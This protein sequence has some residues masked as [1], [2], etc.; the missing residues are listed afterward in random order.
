MA[1][2]PYSAP[3]LINSAADELHGIPVDS[4][5][6][7]L[8][9]PAIED[10]DVDTTMVLFGESQ[11]DIVELHIHNLKNVL[12]ESAYNVEF[13]AL[14]AF[15]NLATTSAGPTPANIPLYSSRP[16]PALNNVEI[17]LHEIFRSLGYISGKFKFKL[18]FHRNVLG[19]INSPA[20]IIGINGERTILDLEY[21]FPTNFELSPLV[22]SFGNR[23]EYYVN[24][25][26]NSLHRVASFSKNIDLST[27]NISIYSITLQ[28]PLPV[29]IGVGAKCCVDI[30]LADPQSD[31]II[32]LPKKKVDPINRLRNPNFS[33]ETADGLAQSTA[34]K[35]WDQ[36]LGSNPT[37]SQQLINKLI[38]S[39]FDSIDLNIDYRQYDKFVFYGSAV[40]RL[41]NFRYKTGLLEYYTGL[42]STL[43]SI[44]P[45]ASE[46]GTNKNSVT[47]KINNVLSGFDGYEK[48][49]YYESS[50]Y[51]S[52]SYGEFTPSTWPKI[53]STA[54]YSLYSISSSQGNDWF[55]GQ[56]TS[57]SLYDKQNIN[58]LVYLVPEH[59]RESE[60]NE[61]YLT[62]VNM[63]GQHFDI[64]WSYVTDLTNVSRRNESLHE[65]LAKDLIYHVL[66]S[67][68]IDSTNGFKLEE[69]WLDAL[70]VNS[71]G[72]YANSGSLHSIP[73]SDIS[74]ETFKRI[75]NNL[76][77]LLK[78]KGTKRG[79]R[80]LINCYGVPA[81]VYRIKEYSGP[82]QYDSP[83]ISR[84]EKYQVLD[85]F[86]YATDYSTGSGAY[87]STPWSQ[88]NSSDIKSLELRFKAVPSGSELST[89]TLIKI[90]TQR[91]FLSGSSKLIFYDGTS[92]KITLSGSFCDNNWWSLLLTKDATTTYNLYAIENKYG[93]HVYQLSG[94]AT[95]TNWNTL[96]G[97]T[98]LLGDST[99]ANKL[100]SASIQEFRA[101]SS[102]LD[103]EAFQQHSLNPQSI[104]GNNSVSI[105]SS[106]SWVST[107][108]YDYTRAYNDLLIRFPLGTTL[109]NF[110]RSSSIATIES[111]HPK[112]TYSVYATASA[113]SGS[114]PLAFDDVYYAWAPNM[115]YDVD[116]N[117]KIRIEDTKLPG[118]LSTYHSIEKSDFESYY[119][120]TPKVGVYFSPQSEI[121]EDIS[122]QFGGITFDNILGD[123]RDDFKPEY[124]KLSEIKSHYNLKFTDK[125]SFWKYTKLI[126]NFDASMFYLIKKFLPARS[127]KVV[128]LVIEPTILDRPKIVQ[129][130]MWQEREDLETSFSKLP[131]IFTAS[132]DYL[133]CNPILIENN[134]TASYDTYNCDPILIS[135]TIDSEMDTYS[136]VITMS[137]AAVSTNV[138]YIHDN[139]SNNFMTAGT[140]N[141]RY[142]G[143]KIS[144]R[145]F[146]IPSSQTPNG[147]PVVEF[148]TNS[149]NIML[150]NPGPGGQIQI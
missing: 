64:L 100:T 76:P 135:R 118:Q 84:N 51:E 68:G 56:L 66:R 67:L 142:N 78:T 111:I 85:K 17:N 5:D 71:A 58:S 81:T 50:S 139:I 35:S 123:P 60:Y 129:R 87:I 144:S 150:N 62:F 143:C 19:S 104:V 69:L 46:V 127:I 89:R 45:S 25:G 122:D 11:A 47:D 137:I 29:E 107:D 93:S 112:R 37:S 9:I 92:N 96:Y 18:N 88:V 49:L 119:L 14:R 133:E 34:F 48:Y 65:G 99:F 27:P 1:L 12:L 121:S 22:D 95:G 106:A 116:I 83:T 28:S 52:S 73:S 147:A 21:S 146:N 117:N 72:N 124:T 101:W 149:P 44:S 86:V 109:Q 43:N 94:S 108:N 59:I 38:S 90:G 4:F 134:H 39:S 41:K 138:E 63:I 91:V 24:L 82:Y 2:N 126:E 7:N 13:R 23:V 57:A 105:Y 53:N 113:F 8:P 16:N 42:L 75:L 136:A 36:L 20:I 26:K 3:Q 102:T 128:G 61:S 31:T 148:W 97:S 131:H 130:Q 79:I 145:D 77:Y 32:I 74:K 125:N 80:A 103:Y 114:S 115:G 54:P 141:N 40:E 98:L 140:F 120:D 132:Y 55:L 33:I 110:D 6:A 70:G 15:R 10:I 30:Q